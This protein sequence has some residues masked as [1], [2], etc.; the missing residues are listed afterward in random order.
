ML[1]RFDDRIDPTFAAVDRDA[2]IARLRTVL[3]AERLIT[4]AEGMRV[5][6]SDGL[7]AYRGMPGVV[8][9]PDTTAEVRAVLKICAAMG[10]SSSSK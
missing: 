5:Y 1:D 10:R 7:A 9:L 4:R 2:L 6:E 8:A 3:S